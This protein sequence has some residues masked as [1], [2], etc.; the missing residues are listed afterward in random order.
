M[1]GYVLE[2]AQ[3]DARVVAGAEAEEGAIVTRAL[4]RIADE[5]P[6]M[7][8]LERKVEPC[9][10]PDWFDGDR[11]ALA[12]DTEVV[13][14]GPAQRLAD[15]LV[16]LA[17][18]GASGAGVVEP[19]TVVVS[20]TLEALQSEDGGCE[21]EGAGVV[22]PEIARRIACDSRLQIVLRDGKGAALGV[23]REAR[24][25]PGYMRRELMHRDGGCTFPGCGARRYLQA[26]HIIH[27]EHD[28]RTELD[29]L[30]LV[31]HFHHKLLHEHRWMVDLD[32]RQRARWFRPDGARYDPAPR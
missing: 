17:A 18:G 15:A 6:H 29:N 24:V 32:E 27:W 9:E 2:L 19:A 14:D 22:H 31:C 5:L 4:R 3:R 8:A 25:V 10:I 11:A 26:H 21:I 7:P 23:G 20:T 13:E 30:T 28:G 1:R 16:V 12:G